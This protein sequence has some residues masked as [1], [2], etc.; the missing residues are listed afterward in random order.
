ME[1]FE[2]EEIGSIDGIDPEFIEQ[3]KKYYEEFMNMSYKDMEKFINDHR[4]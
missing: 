4:L 1:D 3:E 2:F